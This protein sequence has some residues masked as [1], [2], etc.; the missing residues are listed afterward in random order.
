M[1]NRDLTRAALSS[2][3]SA[4]DLAD[5]VAHFFPEQGIPIQEDLQVFATEVSRDLAETL[6]HSTTPQTAE[7]RELTA[8]LAKTS[9]PPTERVTDLM[10]AREMVL[11]NA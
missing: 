5:A 6:A 9:I 4:R 2:L 7:I 10:A 3:E 8:F 1:C 11:L